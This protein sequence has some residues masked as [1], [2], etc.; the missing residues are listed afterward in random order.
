MHFEI[1]E[2]F[3]LVLRSYPQGKVHLILYVLDDYTLYSG[4]VACLQHAPANTASQHEEKQ[5][6]SI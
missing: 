1:L 5:E 2:M 3:L 6:Y 4:V